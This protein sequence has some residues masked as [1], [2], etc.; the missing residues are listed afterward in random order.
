MV[1]V[2][3]VIWWTMFSGGKS[4]TR[5]R[6]DEEIRRS[7]VKPKRLDNVLGGKVRVYKKLTTENR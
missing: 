1:C 6:G 2:E 7:G 4:A 5:R 3:D